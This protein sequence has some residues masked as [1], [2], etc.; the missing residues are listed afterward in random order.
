M[1]KFTLDLE[2]LRNKTKEEKEEEEEI[3]KKT[4]RLSNE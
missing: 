1:L 2:A 3:K 4:L